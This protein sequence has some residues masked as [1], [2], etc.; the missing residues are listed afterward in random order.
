MS[1]RKKPE[2]FIQRLVRQIWRFFDAVT[3]P[4]SNGFR[5]SLLALKRRSSPSQ[6][7]F[8]LPTVIMVILVVIL[9]TTA[10]LFRSF[11]R[12]KNA[13]NYRVDEVVLNAAT[14][15]LDRARAKLQRLFSPDENRLE[16]N[17]PEENNIAEVLSASN[18]TFGDEVQL[19][20]AAEFNGQGGPQP[21]EQLKTAW[22]FPVDT[23]NDGY[24]DSFTLYGIYFRNPRETTGGRPTRARGPLE[25][26][27]LPMEDTAATGCGSSNAGSAPGWYEISGQLKK[28][29]FI[30]VANVPITQ[31]LSAPYKGNSTNIAPDKFKPY[32]GNKGF[33]ALEMQQD[34]ARTSLDNNAV[35]YEDDL[36]IANVPNFRLNGRVRT[37]GNLMVTNPTGNVIT[38]YQVSSPWSCYWNAE[39][40]KIE[41]GGNV[42]AGNIA[43]DSAVPANPRDSNTDMV[44][45]HLYK[46]REQAYDINANSR[47]IN[48]DNKTTRDI[49]PEVAYN[50]DA[51]ERRLKV[52]I[53]GV[54]A[55]L[56]PN[57]TINSNAVRRLNFPGEDKQ[58]VLD[59]FNDRC[60]PRECTDP[61]N[62]LRV[63]LENYFKAR[64]RRVPYKEVPVNSPPRDAVKA[65]G[66]R[67]TK[68]NVFSG[69]RL[70]PPVEW[71]EIGTNELDLAINGNRMQLTTTDPADRGGGDPLE[72]NIGDR[73][74]V[75]NG[76]PNRW[77]NDAINNYVEEG[78]EQ[79]TGT[80]WDNQAGNATTGEPRVRTSQVEQLEDLG[81]TSRNGFWEKAAAKVEDLKNEDLAGGLRVITG[82]GIYVD[83]VSQGPNGAGKREVDG[84][85]NSFLPP[86]PKP[87]QAQI[88]ENNPDA[89]PANLPRNNQAIVVW[90]DSMPMH[91]WVNTRTPNRREPDEVMKGDLQMRATVVYHYNERRRGEYPIACIS[92][93]YDPTDEVAAQNERRLG[94]VIGGM[95]NNGLN[96]PPP[97]T[98]RT[99]TPR[100]RRQ[101]NMVYPDGRLVNAA[102][103]AAIN[104]A[105]GDLTL[106]D[107]AAIDAA[108]CAFSILENPT[109]TGGSLVPPGAIVER[110]FLDARQVKSLHKPETIPD[111]TLLANISDPDQLKLPELEELRRQNTESE[112]DL[113]IEQRQPLEI[114]VTEIDLRAIKGVSVAGNTAGGVP[115]NN[116]QEFLLPNSGII[117]A[118]R[119]DALPDISD[120]DSPSTDFRAD[121][122][123]RPMGIRLINGD[124]LSRI[125][126]F[127]TPEKGL[128]L[129]S[130]LPV[131]IKG[132]FNRH[133]A[134]TDDVE[135]FSEK[136][137][138]D[139][140]NFYQRQTKEECFAYRTEQGDCR[141]TGDRW[142]PARILS[143]AITLLSDNFRDGYR[144]E[145]DY[146]LRNNAGNS[147]VEARLN[148]GFWW[149]S[150]ATTANWYNNGNG[151][152]KPDF[153]LPPGQV[154][155]Q[156]SSY[157][158]NSV[159]PVQRRV[160]FPVYKME[161][162][163]TLPV[164]ECDPNGPKGW[165]ND[166]QSGTTATDTNTLRQQD[167]HFA[168]RVAFQ[169]D[170]ANYGQLV[171]DESNNAIPIGG[172]GTPSP[173]DPPG[174][175]PPTTPASDD[176]ALWFWTTRTPNQPNQPRNPANGS[177]APTS[178]SYDGTNLLYYLPDELERPAPPQ[179]PVVHERQLLLPGTPIL[180]EDA[181]TLAA[182]S[183]TV[184]S[185]PGAAAAINALNGDSDADPSDYSLCIPARGASKKYKAQALNDVGAGCATAKGSIDNARTQLLRLQVPPANRVPARGTFPALPTQTLSPDDRVNVFELRPDL[186]NLT[187]T[188]RRN[189]AQKDPIVILKSAGYISFNGGVV[190][191]LE[192]VDPNN[193]FW[194]SRQGIYFQRRPGSVSNNQLAGNFIGGT[195]GR[196]PLYIANSPEITGGRFLGFNNLRLIP[197]GSSLPSSILALT[198]TNQPLLVPMLQ[199]HS[200][201][202]NPGNPFTSND[203]LNTNWLPK[204]SNTTFNASFIMGDTPARPFRNR[205]VNPG[206]S[207][208]GLHN[209]P[210]FIEDWA[211]RIGGTSDTVARI[212]GSF[213]QFKRSSFAT[214]PFE[215]ID[216]PRRDTSLFFDG[217]NPEYMNNYRDRDY[218]YKGG[219]QTRKAPYY[220][221]PDRQ[222]GYDVGLLR[223]TPDLFSRRFASPAAGTPNEFYREVG[224]DD[225]WIQPLLCA[226]ESRNPSSPTPTYEFTIPDPRQRPA[227]C[228][229][230]APGPEY[231]ATPD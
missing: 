155:N 193:V 208:G 133:R 159:T 122:T 223:I 27:A 214:A 70:V 178:F 209:F 82:A 25:A 190:L 94:G 205:A 24:F 43:G 92:S 52:L 106:Q 72:Y 139:Y 221:A 226:A 66:A 124:D 228:Q 231:N 64:V 169:R 23:N 204:A 58:E 53:D 229:Q 48:A 91:R 116:N 63:T 51:Y 137:N 118:S 152:P 115:A 215:T 111:E 148:K 134:G 194:V 47:T 142:R 224:R 46:E 138:P 197:A 149:N 125:Q 44:T 85:R 14:P 141:A 173:Y 87:T 156:G 225:N 103:N 129:A 90:P 166:A 136:L 50:S 219:A 107:K 17:T 57:P 41:V 180:P 54:F 211:G 22:K 108:N 189:P 179:V 98:S 227:S 206:E 210:R 183:P 132:N 81:D 198:T 164:S 174:A 67:M 8:V 12:S 182:V 117:Y 175:A 32:T 80:E 195:A 135:E 158:T 121:H 119:D 65:G 220:L 1:A 5:R 163:R 100:L 157:V 171:L 212:R 112:Y 18:Y 19:T 29:F 35:W 230:A 71:M 3:K 201:T 170:T 200:P 185:V 218:R 128:I 207:G 45:V 11:D 217:A 203:D 192:G 88:R 202:G 176:N 96:Y 95:S 150:F 39:N 7:G 56:G 101:A 186:Q 28:A 33:S 162:C 99:V 38:F 127:R 20:L 130:D 161:I 68:N 76:L 49:P 110:A 160:N 191:K 114:R 222:W 37:N 61:E 30:Y 42:T 140:S 86:P 59:A 145:G 123:R 143:D 216:D 74:E 109:A 102:L 147:V 181:P 184:S 78:Q 213:I 60:P 9:L 105:P 177:I 2:N 83:G 126:R 146:D 120:P 199:L 97:T 34:Q 15:A 172:N 154:G 4:L 36:E 89:D 21:E 104:K 84:G 16:G 26:R 77:W 144:I 79:P 40:A 153:D 31:P 168:R 93:Y 69:G 167:K 73:V 187:I 131:Y 55:Q 113:P 13:S 165:L 75:G 10:I 196:S 62:A 6:A 188:L 151:L